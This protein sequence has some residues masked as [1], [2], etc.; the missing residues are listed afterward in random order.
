MATVGII[1]DIILVAAVV[2]FGIIGYRKGFL[3]SILSLFSWIVCLIVAIFAAKHVAGWINGIYDFEGLFGD[4]IANNL[5]KSDKSFFGAAISQFGSI[6]NLEKAIPGDTN[7]LVA[8]LIKIIFS[9]KSVDMSSNKTVADVVG[10]SLGHIIMVVVAGILV[11]VVLMIVVGILTKL[12]NKISSTKVIGG[13]NKILGLILGVL[14]AGC[15]VII[16]NGVLIGLS[17]VPPINKIISPI[18]QENT[19]VEK[20][21]YNQTDKVVE[22]YLIE[23]DVVEKWVNNLWDNRK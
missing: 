8:Q 14:K 19:F 20:F 7:K 17:L 11:F 15:I 10:S 12:L 3:K 21:V 9:D 6:D 13:L 5:I 2:I 1:I 22:K 18:I 16:F 23:G 4:K